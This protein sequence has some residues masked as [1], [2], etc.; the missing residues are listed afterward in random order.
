MAIIAVL[1]AVVSWFGAV[2]RPVCHNVQSAYVD[3]RC[4]IGPAAV[5]G[6]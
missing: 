5:R 1:V 6:E 4:A 2:D 3:S